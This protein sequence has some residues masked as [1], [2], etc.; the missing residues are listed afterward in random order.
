MYFFRVLDVELSLPQGVYLFLGY[1]TKDEGLLQAVTGEGVMETIGAIQGLVSYHNINNNKS[2]CRMLLQA[3]ENE[4]LV[5]QAV[6]DEFDLN[7]EVGNLT[8]E[9][10]NREKVILICIWVRVA[11]TMYSMFP[12]LKS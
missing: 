11:G 7:R 12:K 9:L 4:N 1:S 8:A 2:D 3:H 6:M 5:L 10:L